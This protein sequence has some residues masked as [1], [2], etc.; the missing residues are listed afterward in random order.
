MKVSYFCSEYPAISHTFISKEVDELEKNGYE[1]STVSVNY[2]KNYEKMSNSDKERVETTYYLKREN[3][4]KILG[5]IFKYFFKN[6]L[7]YIIV[8]FYTL[9]IS[10]FGGVKNFKKAIGYFIEAI[11]LDNEMK[12]KDVR[13][14]H[15]HFA[16]SA[17]TVALIA[18][19]FKKIDF[20]ISV[21]GPDIFYN[22]NEN[23]IREKVHE[24]KFIRVISYFCQSQLMRESNPMN[25]D[26]FNIARC[27]VNL[28]QFKAIKTKTKN[29]ILNITCVG[30]LTPS[31]G[32]MILV[33]TAKLLKDKKMKFK[34]TL[35]G[36]GED[37][38]IIQEALKKMGLS[39]C[40]NLTGPVSHDRVK[41]ILST[42]DVFVLPS[43]AEG[44]PVALMEAMAMEIPVISTKITGIHE[45][46]E[47]KVDGFLVEA[48]NEIQLGDLLS[49]II[50]GKIDLNKIK[51]NA[52]KKV[53]EKYDINKNINQMI[54]MFNKNL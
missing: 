45:L 4:I 37:F 6:P 24:S 43:F 13:H 18:S 38:E 49:D 30:R 17:A 31:K 27:G 5:I 41:E 44:V 1:I 33:K 52:R 19:K 23:L 25:W 48:S 47:D 54:E 20:S 3:K 35:V 39:D 9:K 53:V 11:L 2:P 14:V 15:V 36:G 7:L 8:W 29:E 34:L 16:N 12:K 32:Q 40:V 21:H 10:L 26:K 51:E 28:E 42:S 46:I 50:A 22:I